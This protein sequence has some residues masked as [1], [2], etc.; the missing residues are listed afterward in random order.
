MGDF[1]GE[2]VEVG[3]G[4]V[5]VSSCC[6]DVGLSSVDGDSCLGGWVAD[7]HRLDSWCTRSVRDS[8]V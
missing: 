2:E 6:S 1:D 5:V 7:R 8:T 4:C 3:D